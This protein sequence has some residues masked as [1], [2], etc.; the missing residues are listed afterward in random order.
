VLS[1]SR[2]APISIDLSMLDG[3]HGRRDHRG[4][5]SLSYHCGKL[6]DPIYDFLRRSAPQGHDSGNETDWSELDLHNGLCATDGVVEGG[7]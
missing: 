3:L 4:R 1:L 2:W 5:C 7:A 6:Q